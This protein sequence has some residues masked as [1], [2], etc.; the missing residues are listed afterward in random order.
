MQ[1]ASGSTT[2]GYDTLGRVDH[3]TQPANK[4]ITYSYDPLG[5]RSVMADPDGGPARRRALLP[6]GGRTTYSYD[7]ANRLTSL[8]NPFNERTTWVYDALSRA[9]T[10]T[11]A[12]GAVTTYAYDAAGRLTLL[13]NTKSDGTTIS[14]FEYGNDS[15]GNRTGVL[16][17]NGDRVTWSYDA[18]YQLTRERRSGANA[19]DITYSYDPVGNR[20]TKVASG[21]S[22]TYSYDAANELT[23]EN[24]AGTVTTYSYDANGNTTVKNAAGSLTT[25]TWEGENRLSKIESGD[26]VLTMTYDADGLRR[27]KQDSSATAKF[28]W[29]GQKVLLETDAQDATVAAYAL[30]DDVYGDLLSQR[31]SGASSFYHF[32]ALGSTDRLTNAAGT[33]TD[34]YTYYAFGQDRASSGTSTNPYRYVGR[35]GYYRNGTDLLYLRARYYRA[36]N[37]RFASRD[38]LP[39]PGVNRYLY[40]HNAPLAW[41]DP[42]GRLLFSEWFCSDCDKHKDDLGWLKY[43][44]CRFWCMPDPPPGGYEPPGPEPITPVLPIEW[45][46]SPPGGPIF[47]ECVDAEGY[48][49]GR[50]IN[51]TGCN[52]ILMSYCASW[53]VIGTQIWIEDCRACHTVCEGYCT[54]YATAPEAWSTFLMYQCWQRCMP[55]IMPRLPSPGPP[56]VI[57]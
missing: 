41:C 19:Y 42:S 24:A 51:C 32:D 22:T 15:V 50:N 26:G 45:P 39:S 30:S 20:V 54:A 6:A 23:I 3:V 9:S 37:G 48:C 18:L 11:L 33:V 5:S 17:A 56:P 46:T 29:D 47:P 34:S 10:L 27:K 4:T 36:A 21:V 12:N 13:R 14:S 28:I 35:L 8:L 55:R 52:F 53:A 40:V 25:Y 2:Y 49:F 43:K 44:W 31:R 16:E 38:P 7:A 1:D 57:W